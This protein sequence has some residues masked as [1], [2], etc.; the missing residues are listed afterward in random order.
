MDHNIRPTHVYFIIVWELPEKS[1][2]LI[3]ATT[4][5]A[6]NHHRVK[7]YSYQKR[8]QTNAP[9]VFEYLVK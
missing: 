6:E 7:L 4:L 1:Q 9:N 3:E 8:T 5:V 2:D